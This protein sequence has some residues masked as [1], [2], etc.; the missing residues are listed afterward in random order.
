[1]IAAAIGAAVALVLSYFGQSLLVVAA[2]SA[3]AIYL[4]GFI[5]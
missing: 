1:V 3:A 5:F 2:A 4:S